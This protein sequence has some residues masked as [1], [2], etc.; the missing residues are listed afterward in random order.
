MIAVITFV[1][2]VCFKIKS[3][4]MKVRDFFSFIRAIN[5]LDNLYAYSKN[6][7]NM[8]KIEQTL[9]LKEAEKVF[10]KFEKVPSMIWEEEYGKYSQV[11]ETYRNIRLMQWSEM[12]V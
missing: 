2:I 11:L 1:S 10:S 5:D 7:T 4:G 9:F 6:N 8:T 12:A 3:N